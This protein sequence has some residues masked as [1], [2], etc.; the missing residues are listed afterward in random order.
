MT[1]QLGNRVLFILLLGGLITHQFETL[2]LDKHILTEPDYFLQ[3]QKHS[4]I[5]VLVQKLYNLLVGINGFNEVR[6]LQV[7]KVMKGRL[8]SVNFLILYSGYKYQPI[9]FH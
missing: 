7:A 2:C 8:Q 1:E 9:L 4:N 3:C 6:K 5:F